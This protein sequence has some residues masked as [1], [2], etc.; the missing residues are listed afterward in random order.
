MVELRRE[1]EVEHA[2][3]LKQI[4]AGQLDAA[5]DTLTRVDALRDIFTQRIDTIRAD[6]L[7]QVFAST[8]TVIR[9]QR[10]AILI[11]AIVTGLAAVV[12]M[13][14]AL[15]VSSGITRPVRLLARRHE[16]CRPGVSTIP[17]TSRP[18]TRSASL[19]SPSTE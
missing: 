1:L 4:E 7:T 16:R 6:M 5:R 18:R 8:T 12:G 17:S 9:N 3:L 14:F 13:V 19:P 10:Q 2:K 15:M 11:S